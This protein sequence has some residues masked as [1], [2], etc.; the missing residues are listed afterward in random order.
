MNSISIEESTFPAAKSEILGLLNQGDRQFDA[1]FMKWRYEDR[2]KGYLVMCIAQTSE[3]KIVGCR[4]M[5]PFVFRVGG[6][7]ETFGIQADLF[8]NKEFR[9]FGLGGRLVKFCIEKT[10]AKGVETIIGMPNQVSTKIQKKDVLRE[11]GVVQ[12]YRRYFDFW[13]RLSKKVSNVDLL[14]LL[15]KISA[16][17]LGFLCP[18]ER[19]N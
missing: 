6:H 1:K 16:I 17:P 18:E 5:F 19:I 9:E 10:M 13:Y 14:N 4:A 11:L 3:G 7:V 12:G 8:V 15:T 2:P